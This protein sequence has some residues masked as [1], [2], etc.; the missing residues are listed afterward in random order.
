MPLKTT[1]PRRHLKRRCPRNLLPREENR[2][3]LRNHPSRGRAAVIQQAENGK[4][5][6]YSNLHWNESKFYCQNMTMY[7]RSDPRLWKSMS[8]FNLTLGITVELLQLHVWRADRE[9]RLAYWWIKDLLKYN[10]QAFMFTWDISYIKP[11]RAFWGSILCK[12]KNNRFDYS[13]YNTDTLICN[14]QMCLQKCQLV[15]V[16]SLKKCI[17][18]SRIKNIPHSMSFWGLAEF[19]RT[20]YMF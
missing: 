3:D 12:I 19:A 7:L 17:N 8:K 10:S 20:I 18:I 2:G 15:K 4:K 16:S 9:P 13:E 5:N 14:K 1:F 6:L 11:L